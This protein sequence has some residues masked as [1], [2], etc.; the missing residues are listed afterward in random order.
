VQI[1]STDG[2]PLDNYKKQSQHLTM[3][4]GLVN[5]LTKL[6]LNVTIR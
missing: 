3:K 5:F 2:K 1:G 4:T 6:G